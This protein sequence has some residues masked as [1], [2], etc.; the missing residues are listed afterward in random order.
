MSDPVKPLQV[1]V[2]ED[3]TIIRRLLASTVMAAGAELVGD[4]ADAQSAIDDLSK[5]RADLVLI[6]IA[7]KSGTG[8]DV[9][10]ALQALESKTKPIK[11]VLTNHANPEYEAMSYRMGANGFFDKTTQTLEVLALINAL[12]SEKR[13]A[14]PPS[15]RPATPRDPAGPGMG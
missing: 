6:D 4:S 12:A 3:S 11:V 7:L 10:E 15:T 14:P 1:Y 9:L 13:R 8:F 2:V 5:I